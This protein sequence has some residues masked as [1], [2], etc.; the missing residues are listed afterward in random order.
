MKPKKGDELRVNRTALYLLPSLRKYGENYRENLT[1][2]FKKAF[3]IRDELDDR[4]GK[5]IY[6]LADASVNTKTFIRVLNWTRSQPFYVADYEF[7][8][9]LDGSLHM[10]VLHVPN[11]K[12]YDNFMLSNYSQ[13]YT[14]EE[15]K[16]YIDE[17]SII[18]GVFTRDKTT[19]KKYLDEINKEWETEFS[20]HQWTGEL[21]YP[22]KHDEEVFEIVL[23]RKADRREGS[24]DPLTE[25]GVEEQII[26]EPG[27]ESVDGE[28]LYPIDLEDEGVS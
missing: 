22:W 1:S 7:D 9:M 24:F 26:T 25:S 8:N 3:G 27:S 20:A 23:P 21:D 2:I 16:H 11:T 4:D 12:A 15:V 19:V 10:L 17:D 18:L 13:M 14:A 5:N 28:G 6:I